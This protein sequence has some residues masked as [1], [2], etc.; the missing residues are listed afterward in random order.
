MKYMENS[1]NPK[2]NKDNKQSNFAKIL[3]NSCLAIKKYLWF[4]PYLLS[5]FLERKEFLEVSLNLNKHFI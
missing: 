3:L 1:D 2:G 4:V 5:S